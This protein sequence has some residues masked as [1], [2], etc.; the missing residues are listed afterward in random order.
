[1]YGV[2][3]VFKMMIDID[4]NL[5]M[6][7]KDIINKDRIEYPTLKSFVERAIRD[8]VRIE[9]INQRELDTRNLL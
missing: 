1:M 6:Q 3:G 4:E 9:T 5:Y 7:V 2:Y 8:K